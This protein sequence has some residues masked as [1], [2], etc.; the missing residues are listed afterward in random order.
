[1]YVNMTRLAIVNF[2]SYDQ[3]DNLQGLSRPPVQ[4]SGAVRQLIQGRLLGQRRGVR[5]SGQARAIFKHID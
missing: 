3:F 4:D 5:R 2:V 1:M